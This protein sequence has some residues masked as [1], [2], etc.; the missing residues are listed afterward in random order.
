MKEDAKDQWKYFKGLCSQ[1]S[2]G[3]STVNHPKHGVVQQ[4]LNVVDHFH[5]ITRATPPV[6]NF[7][8][9]PSGDSL[10]LLPSFPVPGEAL[11]LSVGLL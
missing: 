9:I 11:R 2:A 7:T 5:G 3:N 4:L 8:P 10:P 6:G 1:A